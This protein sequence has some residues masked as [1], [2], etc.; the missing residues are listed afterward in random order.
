MITDDSMKTLL[1]SHHH[2]LHF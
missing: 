1:P 2:G